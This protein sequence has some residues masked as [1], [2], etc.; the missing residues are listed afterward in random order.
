M[1]RTLDGDRRIGVALGR[2]AFGDSGRVRLRTL[3]LIQWVAIAGQA[4]ALLFVEF[5]LG[6]EL[7]L[8][9]A[10]AIIAASAVLNLAITIDRPAGL[11]LGDTAAAWYLGFD[12]CQL[13]ALLYLTGGLEN[14]FAFLLL[15]P[16]T[17]SATILS[18]RVTVLLCILAL[19]CVSFL[20]LFHWPLPWIDGPLVLPFILVVGTWVAL[21]LGIVFFAAYT[22][23]VAEEARRM[24]DALGATQMA[25]ARE[26]Q[27]SA[28]GGLAAA[29]A[30]ELG[31]PLGTIVLV[32]REL[33]RELP[34]D[35]PLAEDVTL[36]I[37]QADR[38]RRILADFAARPGADGG[39]P[40]TDIPVDA[41]VEAAG[42]P[43]KDPR[44][45]VVFDA[46]PAEA[47]EDEPAPIVV[48]SP[49]FIHGLGNLIQNAV[50][51]ARTEVVVRTRW[52]AA[53]IAV[54]IADDGAGFPEH[55][56]ERLGEPYIS[57]RGRDGRHMGLGVFIAKT[58]LAGTGASVAFA[59]GGDGG[60]E[61]T[62][63]WPR[64]A[65]AVRP[66]VATIE[67]Q[68]G[69]GAHGTSGLKEDTERQQAQRVA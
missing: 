37:S 39:K 13:T 61:V 10:L 42:A 69:A 68:H 48:R 44:V 2:A 36:L 54:I 16:V 6:F 45:V 65:L 11:R 31:S 27:M 12:I 21:A 30:H 3:A 33:E 52:S 34:K 28:L 23:R 38:C 62:V 53:E 46:G 55:V 35:S 25:L 51:F 63:R 43:H 8:V 9:P 29:A 60:A 7:P 17:V 20:A 26:Q 40:F 49:E 41:L 59:N 4:V 56:L 19:A 24:S 22:W 57:G 32:A 67:T 18:R 64:A 1:A 15:A 47:A 66:A 50:Q 5:V 14:P 58:L